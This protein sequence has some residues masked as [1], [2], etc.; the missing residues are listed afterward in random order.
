MYRMSYVQVNIQE[1]AHRR[2]V[3]PAQPVTYGYQ[4]KPET[5]I[6]FKQD[7]PPA[8]SWESTVFIN[9]VCVQVKKCIILNKV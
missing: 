4:K 5:A 3:L 2:L 6:I 9:S 8:D 7:N 1:E